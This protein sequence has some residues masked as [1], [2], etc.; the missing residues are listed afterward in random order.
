L[1]SFRFCCLSVVSFESTYSQHQILEGGGEIKRRARNETKVRFRF[2]FSCC[3]NY[4]RKEIETLKEN[5]KQDLKLRRRKRSESKK[6]TGLLSSDFL[7]E[8]R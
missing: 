4:K 3:V 1:L 7:S 6:M 2:R 5:S 8:R